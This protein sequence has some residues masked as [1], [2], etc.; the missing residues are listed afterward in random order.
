[1][2][3]AIDPSTPH[4]YVCKE[5]RELPVEEQTVIL[6]RAVPLSEFFEIMGMTKEMPEN[7][8]DLEIDHI[9]ELLVRFIAGWENFKNAEGKLIEPEFEI[10]PVNMMQTNRIKF[11]SLNMFAPKHL[12]EIFEEVQRIN[13]LGEKE[14]KN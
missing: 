5:D 10:N 3:L 2:V 4:R 13:G 12:I 6:L 1:M 9:K 7:M 11:S 14:I 8:K